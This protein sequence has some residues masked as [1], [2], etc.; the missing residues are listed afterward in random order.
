MT[1]HDIT[2]VTKYSNLW[3]EMAKQSELRE[4]AVLYLAKF[5]EKWSIEKVVNNEK[6]LKDNHFVGSILKNESTS[7]YVV[8]YKG[9]SFCS[10]S[11]IIKDFILADGEIAIGSYS[12]QL[13]SAKDLF[14]TCMDMVNQDISKITVVGHSL[15]GG[16]AEFIGVLH[17]VET[18]AFDALGVRRVFEN[19]PSYGYNPNDNYD[20]IHNY[21]SIIDMV[22]NL[23]P[24]CNKNCYFVKKPL[25]YIENDCRLEVLKAEFAFTKTL[26]DKIS[27][28]RKD[29]KINVQKNTLMIPKD[30]MLETLDI[31]YIM[32]VNLEKY[33]YSQKS[34]FSIALPHILDESSLDW[35]NTWKPTQWPRDAHKVSLFY[36][37]LT[38]EDI[39]DKNTVLL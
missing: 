36:D 25:N 29:L 28:L 34:V 6:D 21:M 13:K 35:L 27:A 37:N 26:V 31:D 33:M 18:Y 1:V 16:L 11:G 23:A 15:G 30:L 14:N 39:Y 32:A 7:E 24:H 20:N 4:R 12:S 22:G 8:T 2:K 10:F 9:T 38:Q 19:D 3:D 5:D 17:P